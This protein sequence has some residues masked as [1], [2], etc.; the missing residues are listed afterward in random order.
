MNYTELRP[1]N[2]VRAVLNKD[3]TTVGWVAIRLQEKRPYF[4]GIEV[5]GEWLLKLGFFLD[6]ESSVYSK[7]SLF[8]NGFQGAQ[9][10]NYYFY[11]AKKVMVADFELLGFENGIELDISEQVRYVHQLQ[12]FVFCV[13]GQEL[14]K[15]Y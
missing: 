14:E 9:K 6:Y 13:C 2:L 15:L 1:G 11:P 12:N 3:I 4:E 10:I 8:V 5:D 7:Y